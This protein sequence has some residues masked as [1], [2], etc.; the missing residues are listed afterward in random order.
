MP[1]T[2]TADVINALKSDHLRIA[3]LFWADFAS[4]VLSLASTPFDLTYLGVKYTGAGGIGTISRLQETSDFQ[5]VA[6]DF[7]LRGIPDDIVAMAASDQ[8]QNRRCRLYLAMLDSNYQIIPDPGVVFSGRMNTI[9][10][11]EDP[12]LATVKLRAESRLSDWERPRMR[13]YTLEDHEVD[14]PG[15]KFFEFVPKMVDIP[16]DWGK[17]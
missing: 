14:A 9:N 1:R 11:I 12:P 5:V 2:L 6:M 3:F 4:G 8:Y 16:I 13:R 15:D 10:T 17:T 7:E